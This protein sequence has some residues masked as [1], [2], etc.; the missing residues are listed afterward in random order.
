[1]ADSKVER[2][3][4]YLVMPELFTD[5]ERAA[6]DFARSFYF[7]L[8]WV[9]D[10]VM[11]EAKRHFEPAEIVELAFCLWQFMGGNWF[12]H[13]LGIEPEG[14]I[15]EYYGGSKRLGP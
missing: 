1:L 12:M 5:R 6:L 3:Q 11:E 8:G 10:D 13:A 15:G 2:V 9:D 7:K 14:D 4:D